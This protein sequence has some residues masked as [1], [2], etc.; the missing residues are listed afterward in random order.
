MHKREITE[1]APPDL[2]I[3]SNWSGCIMAIIATF[4]LGSGTLLQDGS[5]SLNGL[6]VAIML[7]LATGHYY[8]RFQITKPANNQSLSAE[9]EGPL[10]LVVIVWT[11]FR[12]GASFLPSLIII[13]AMTIAWITIHYHG[14]ATLIC[15]LVVVAVEAALTL[16][17][18]QTLLLASTNIFFCAIVVASLNFFPGT[19][20]YKTKLRQARIDTDQ[21]IASQEQA[22]EMGLT[23]DHIS[24]PEILQGLHNFDHS[25]S[26]SQQTVESV[27]KSFELQLEMIR[28]ALNLTTIAVLWPDPAN[29]VLRLRYLAT[30][31]EDINSGPYPVGTGITGALS[32][33]HEETELVGVKPSHPALPYYRKNGRVGSILALRIP[34]NQPDNVKTE[35]AKTGIL[36][37]DR[38]S[39]SP[40]SDRERQVLRLTGKKLGLEISGCRLLLNMDRQRATINR[41]CHGLRELNSDPSLESIFAASIKA[42]KAQVQTDLLALCLRSGDRHQIVLAEGAGTDKLTNHYFPIEEGLVGQAIKTGRTL[43]AGGRYLGAAPIFS[44]AQTFTAYQS[45]LVVPLP[46]EDNTPIG[47]LV[48]AAKDPGV[49]TKNHQEIL[50]IIAA[51][52][53]INIKLGQA[54]EQLGVQATTD[55]LTGLVN[56]QTFQHGCEVMLERATRNGN[57]LCLLLADLDYFKKINDNFGHPFGDLVLREVAK[58][59]AETVRT[60][61]L[62]ARY[63]GEEFAIVLENCDGKSGLI[64]AEKIRKRIAQLHLTCGDKSITVTLSTG[65]AVFPDNCSD[66]SS[67]IEL[68]DQALYRAKGAGRN[69]TVLCSEPTN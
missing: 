65:I 48:V 34:T 14:L 45:L 46:D 43:P 17:G 37:A 26:F 30:T 40:W 8:W 21:D 7:T 20:S 38:E 56:H 36:C 59:M 4:A 10:L 58:V 47:C 50:E 19:K 41:L 63:G 23:G 51:Q 9:L 27:N 3:F 13:P 33:N 57:H 28:L 62:A 2:T 53:T 67:L 1:K 11:I 22:I 52:I 61:D 16:T 35:T 64:L 24:A 5:P 69:Q 49:F 55:G 60:V 15:V 29:D 12:L 6:I 44:N 25:K 31:R 18:N 54:H 32:G 66:K 39:D 42:V 68:A